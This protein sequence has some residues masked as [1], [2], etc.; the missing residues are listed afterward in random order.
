MFKL[1]KECPTLILAAFK[2]FPL[3]IA[4]AFL[5]TFAF[6][7]I[8]AVKDYDLISVRANLF[9]LWV[10][11][12]PVAAM[13]ISLTTSLIQESRKST[14]K[15]PQILTNV[16]WLAISFTLSLCLIS[17]DNWSDKTSIMLI[18]I[19]TYCIIG[20]AAYIGP[21]WN[22]KN[23]NAL[24]AFGKKIN[25]P[26]LIPFFFCAVSFILLAVISGLSKG[27]TD[28][29]I[30]ACESAIIFSFFTLF[31]VLCMASI[32]SIDKCTEE[33]PTLENSVTTIK[34]KI[35]SRQFSIS[36]D[37]FKHIFLPLY[38]IYIVTVH[39]YDITALLQ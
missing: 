16:S 37:S 9:T 7:Y 27:S 15:M 20:I 2:R 17:A 33:T 13:L 29:G 24:R 21:F 14:R 23:D 18:I 39:I 6:M 38:A 22:Q 26:I 1:L 10:T 31:P 12:Y 11:I 32:P 5:S 35:K 8:F 3:A 19:C 30:T 34:L 25:I 4:F 36:F 28:P